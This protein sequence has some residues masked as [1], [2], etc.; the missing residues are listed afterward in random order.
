MC[1]HCGSGSGVWGFFFS[2]RRRHTRSLC[3]WS[4]DVCSSDLAHRI[5][6]REVR[7]AVARE[8]ARQNAVVA[9]AVLVGAEMPA[10]TVAEI[11]A[12]HLRMHQAEEIGRASCGERA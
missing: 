2:S 1:H 3:D 11:L 4:S 6:V 5:A 8:K 9:S 7:A 10:W 12:V